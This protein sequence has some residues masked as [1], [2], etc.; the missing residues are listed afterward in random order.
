MMQNLSEAGSRGT[1][2]VGRKLG[3][4][5]R[6]TIFQFLGVVG[7]NVS[8]IYTGKLWNKLKES[9]KNLLIL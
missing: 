9:E 1:A 2:E 8:S 4:A 7:G 6:F 3:H 5:N